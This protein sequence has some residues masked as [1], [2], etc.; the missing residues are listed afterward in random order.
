MGGHL[1]YLFYKSIKLFK[2]TSHRFVKWF[3][4]GYASN[5]G[6]ILT[7]SFLVPI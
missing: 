3:A 4:L 2:K 5:I 1:Y 6:V 7:E